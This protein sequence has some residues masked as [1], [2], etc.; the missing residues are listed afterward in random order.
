VGGKEM[1]KTWPS[2]NTQSLRLQQCP[3][4]GAHAQTGSSRLTRV[5][6]AYSW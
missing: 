2:T 6:Y 4:L 3:M 5:A 1:R